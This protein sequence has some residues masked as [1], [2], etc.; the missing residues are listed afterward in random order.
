MLKVAGCAKLKPPPGLPCCGAMEG[1]AGA[2]GGA[3]APAPKVK[4]PGL[5]L[6]DPNPPAPPNLKPPGGHRV[7][8]VRT[9]RGRS[10]GQG[11]SHAPDAGL[12]AASNTGGV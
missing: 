11:H 3:A 8:K 1:L 7:V 2:A 5:L 6:V 12:E 10:R 4:T 9:A